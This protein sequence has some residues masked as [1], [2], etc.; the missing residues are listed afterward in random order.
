MRRFSR[1]LR[2]MGISGN[3]AQILTCGYKDMVSMPGLRQLTH[4]RKR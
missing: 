2:K 3:E 1:T 4:R